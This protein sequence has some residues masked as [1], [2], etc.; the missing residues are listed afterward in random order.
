MR[1]LSTHAL[2]PVD[3]TAYRRRQKQIIVAQRLCDINIYIH[4]IKNK[5]FKNVHTLN[6]LK[7]TFT[8]YPA[9]HSNYSL[10]NCTIS[11]KKNFNRSTD[12]L[13]AASGMCARKA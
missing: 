9:I 7:Q 8:P 10:S 2:H 12:F 11:N 3:V 1:M 6:E 13:V 5:H 4:Y